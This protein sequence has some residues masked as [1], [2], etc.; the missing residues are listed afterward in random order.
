MSKKSTIGQIVGLIK[1]EGADDDWNK[2]QRW[3]LPEK[4]DVD[5]TCFDCFKRAYL[6]H[7]GKNADIQFPGGVEIQLGSCDTL[8]F[9]I[10]TEIREIRHKLTRLFSIAGC[11][12]ADDENGKEIVRDCETPG[13]AELRYSVEDI[14]DAVDTI[15]GGMLNM[16]LKERNGDLMGAAR[17]CEYH[18][19]LPLRDLN[20]GQIEECADCSNDYLCSLE[21]EAKVNEKSDQAC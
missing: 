16:A 8:K 19:L 3:V 20:G 15:R 12:Y 7:G 11:L 10:A 14:A 13:I 2:D 4:K 18:L 5:S 21:R 17:E 9:A 1:T 6:A